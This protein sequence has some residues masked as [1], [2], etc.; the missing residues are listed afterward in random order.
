MHNLHNLFLH[1]WHLTCR[2]NNSSPPTRPLAVVP[3]PPRPFLNKK[4]VQVVHWAE[5]PI[6]ARDFGAQPTPGGCAGG[7]AAKKPNPV[8][9]RDLGAQ[10]LGPH[11]AQRGRSAHSSPDWA[12]WRAPG[13]PPRRPEQ[14]SPCTTFAVRLCRGVKGQ[15]SQNAYRQRDFS[16]TAQIACTTSCTTL[17]GRLCSSHGC[18]EGQ[19]G[20]LFRLAPHPFPEFRRNRH[21][22]FHIAT[23]LQK[24]GNL[25]LIVLRQVLLVP[26]PGAD[27][28]LA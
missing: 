20:H 15:I 6:T 23:L 18:P 1:T 14:R 16:E 10:P 3:S 25:H 24:L 9:A 2:N 12:G 17:I 28:R 11:R 26:R 22:P 13:R 4:V 27:Q 21:L 7:C 19:S 5:N 8:T